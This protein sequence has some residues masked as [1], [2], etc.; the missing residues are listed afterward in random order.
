MNIIDIIEASRIKE[1]ISAEEL[2]GRTQSVSASSYTGYRSKTTQPPL[3]AVVELLGAVKKRLFVIPENMKGDVNIKEWAILDLWIKCH[4]EQ[5]WLLF[6]QS[7]KLN[8]A[9]HY[10]KIF[11]DI[12]F[13]TWFYRTHKGIPYSYL[14]HEEIKELEIWGLTT[15]NRIPSETAYEF[16]N[17]VVIAL[18]DYLAHANLLTEIDD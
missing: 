10:H 9:A 15:M 16:Y 14:Y 18:N 4:K 2:A 6:N 3:K 1:G 12:L 7:T 13:Y 5:V 17:N 11:R 8:V